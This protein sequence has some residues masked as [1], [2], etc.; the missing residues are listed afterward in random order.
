[1]TKINLLN[2]SV[3]VHTWPWLAADAEHDIGAGASDGCPA[4]QGRT[5]AHKKGTDKDETLPVR[6][7]ELCYFC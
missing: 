3:Y 1:M 6:I 5:T 2:F 4:A 7:P